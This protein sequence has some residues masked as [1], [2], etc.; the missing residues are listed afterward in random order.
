MKKL[1][2]AVG[3]AATF[4]FAQAQ[5]SVTVYGV[6]DVG[7][8]GSSY[9]GTGTSAT[10]KQTANSFGSGAET[11]SRLGFKGSEDL[12]GGSSAFFTVETGLSPESSTVSTWNNRQSFA[13]IKKNGLGEVAFGLQYTPVANVVAATDPGQL[14]GVVGSV[15]NVGT[16]QTFGTPGLQPYAAATSPGI[17]TD[18]YTQRASNAMTLKSANFAGFQANAMYAAN[19]TN[20]TQT[21]S[22]T[23]GPNNAYGYGLSASYNGI[24]KLLLVA[25]YQNFKS[26]Q[27]GT[28]TSPAPSLFLNNGAAGVNIN[29][30][31]TYLGATYDFGIL[32]AYAGYI[33]RKITDTVNSAYTASRSGEQIGVRGYF[34]PVIEAFASYGVGKLQNFGVGLPNNT[35]T[36]YQV[37]SNYYLSKRTNLYAIVGSTQASGQDTSASNYAVGVR[38]TF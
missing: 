1:L 20:T 24:N 35:F 21:N 30:A 33:N 37:G 7:Y 3:L 23:G 8:V 6:L 15:L 36:G 31:Q 10:T 22:T 34:T 12:G 26:N 19:N 29:D 28:L 27:L 14:N 38:H 16:P 5:S 17:A 32:K 2:L 9:N 4:G 13:G 25:G 18:A 11:P